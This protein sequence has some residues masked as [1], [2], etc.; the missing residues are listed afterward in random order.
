M[1]L[2]LKSINL[3]A[4]YYTRQNLQ[5][6]LGDNRRT[7]DYRIQAL[8]KR[9]NLERV[10]PGFYLN[11][12]LLQNSTD[13]K[14][15]LEY[16]GGVLKY[17]SYLSLETV[18]SEAGLLAESVFALTY[19]STKKT[20]IY[21]SESATFSY[22]KISQ[23]LFFGYEDAPI[24]G[25]RVKKARPSKAVFDWIYLSRVSTNSALSQLLFESR[26]NWSVL[27][28]TDKQEFEKWCRISRLPKMAKV[29]QLLKKRGII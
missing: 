12:L 27:T 4:P 16:V 9:G 18:M 26:L 25:G 13:P 15:V 7:L 5:L 19:V 11:K 6:I 3:S 20:K 23:K 10:C 2:D 24:F 21:T 14:A 17:P 22:R 29:Q 1:E 8:I 28:K